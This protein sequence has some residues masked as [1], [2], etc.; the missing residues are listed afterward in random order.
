MCEAAACAGRK[1]VRRFFRWLLFLCGSVLICLRLYPSESEWV[2]KLFY[3]DY[4]YDRANVLSLRL[5]SE[6]GLS[7][8]RYSA[9]ADNLATLSRAVVIILEAVV[10]ALVFFTAARKLR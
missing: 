3:D 8:D 5:V 4:V 1:E 2:S 10:V 6:S 9:H 7:L